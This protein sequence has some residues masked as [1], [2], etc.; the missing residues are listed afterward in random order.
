MTTRRAWLSFWAATVWFLSGSPAWAQCLGD[1]NADSVVTIDEILTTVNNG[2][3]GC[4]LPEPR[5][6][7]NGNG[8]VADRST[9]LMWEQKVAGGNCLHCVED[10]FDWHTAMSDWLSAVNGLL[11]DPDDPQTGLGGY[12][13]WRIPTVAELR[14][15]LDCFPCLNPVL[16]P[17][18]GCSYW[19]SSGSS[20]S[21]T[22]TFSVEMT[23]GVVI[24]VLKETPR[25]VRA[26]RGGFSPTYSV[27]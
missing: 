6:V 17:D 5:F 1:F 27:P 18:I 20:D 4:A 24:G 16:G 9:G 25:C 15:V 3:H 12:T 14:S 19:T 11:D 23:H 8:T 13:D 10:N 2:L 7:D 21:I 26:V 22:T